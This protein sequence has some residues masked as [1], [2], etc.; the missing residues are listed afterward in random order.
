MRFHVGAQIAGEGEALVAQL[1]GV[2]FV[3]CK[4]CK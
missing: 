4:T 3:P 1:A 2:W